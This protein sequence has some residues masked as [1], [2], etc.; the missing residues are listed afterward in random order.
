MNNDSDLPVFQQ[1]TVSFIWSLVYNKKNPGIRAGSK[2]DQ[3]QHGGG[4]V[5]FYRVTVQENFLQ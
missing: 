2:T 5:R 4:D 3:F 1:L